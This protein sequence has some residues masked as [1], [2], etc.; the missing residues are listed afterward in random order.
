MA[1]VLVANVK[2]ILGRM[3]P[4]HGSG[5]DTWATDFVN[6]INLAIR[7]INTQNDLDTSISEIEGSENTV[8]D[9]DQ[10]YASALIYRSAVHMMAMGRRP[11]KN[12]EKLFKMYKDQSIEAMDDMW[13]DL[14]HDRQEDDDEDDIIGLPDAN[15]E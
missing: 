11:A 8:T 4:S 13:W 14:V 10:K 6:A 3:F 2:T 5:S 7:D 9:C 1:D 12:S 15:D